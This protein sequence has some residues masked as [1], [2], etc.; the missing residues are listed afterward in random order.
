MKSQAGAFQ[1]KARIAGKQARQSL[2]NLGRHRGIRLLGCALLVLFAML[3]LTETRGL[4]A[5]DSSVRNIQL[6]LVP[7][8]AA[9]STPT[10]TA[11]SAISET[12]TPTVSKTS[13]SVAT[14]T[15]TT[16]V[17]ATNTAVPNTPTPTRTATLIPTV[18]TTAPSSPTATK[19]ITSTTRTPTPNPTTSLLP[20]WLLPTSVPATLVLI[21]PAGLSTPVW[22]TPAWALLPADYSA[23]AVPVDL[24]T[25]TNP[26]AGLS[27]D[28][29]QTPV[30][31]RATPPSGLDFILRSLIGPE[32]TRVAIADPNL[33]TSNDVQLSDA[34]EPDVD[35]LSESPPLDPAYHVRRL[36]TL[37]IILGVGA[38]LILGP[39]L[40]GTA[41]LYIIWRK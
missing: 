27:P 24:Q 28:V 33:E 37:G 41:A 26:V 30:R 19:T 13:T 17:T 1:N 6:R 32:P 39:G 31:P 22:A 3:S 40:L 29:A 35:T 11:S 4:A 38:T 16:Q 21:K 10:I 36:I 5:D 23:S 18:Q 2:E 7:M 20:W 9:S 14:S 25:P 15:V 12:I 8:L 34:V